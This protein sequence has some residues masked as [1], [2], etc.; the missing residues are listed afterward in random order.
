MIITYYLCCCRVLGNKLI[1]FIILKDH[2]GC[3]L[4]NGLWEA[5]I[6]LG[7][8]IRGHKD[9][10]LPLLGSIYITIPEH[11]EQ[12]GLALLICTA[13]HLKEL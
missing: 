5:K 10:S 7:H 6:E 11:H 1:W 13:D 12:T 2:F 8:C 4:E 3:Y 9:C